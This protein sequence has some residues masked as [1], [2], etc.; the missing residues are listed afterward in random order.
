[1]FIFVCPG[2]SRECLTAWVH[3]MGTS[4]LRLRMHVEIFTGVSRCRFSIGPFRYQSRLCELLFT[5][6]ISFRKLRVL[7][8]TRVTESH[9]KEE[10]AREY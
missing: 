3:A 5:E 4:V 7:F 10:I 9:C 6:Y 8:K 2:F 1:M